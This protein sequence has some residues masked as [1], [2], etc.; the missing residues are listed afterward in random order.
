[1]SLLDVEAVPPQV[2]AW[3]NAN[4]G[5]AAVT[6]YS[7]MTGGFSRVMARLEVSWG[8]GG[9]GVYV[10]RGDPPPE[11]ATLESDRRE[12][13]RLLSTLAGIDEIPTPAARWFIDEAHLGAPAIVIDFLD[14]GSL[15]ASLDRGLDQ[16]EARDRF[17]DLMAA[18][19]RVTPDRVPCL[20]A[21]S[22]WDDHMD[23]LIGRW[24]AV[25]DRHCESAPI[26]RYIASWLDRRRPAPAPLRLVHG[27]F[28]QGNIVDA[29]DGW[30][31]VDWEFARIG[32]PREDLGYYNAYASA[33]PPNLIDADMEG[34]LARFREKTGLD[35]EQVNPV[36]L[37]YFTVLATIGTI[38]PLYSAVAAMAAGE[39]RGVAVAYN[40]QLIPV[41][42]ENFLNAIDQLEAAIAAAEEA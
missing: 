36:T 5:E 34:F 15:Q 4:V 32:D 29:P 37:G 19:S 31:M 10:L 28:Q 20:P 18:V 1:M 13:W 9:D 3:L 38:D 7:I 24:R 12:E 27:D 8:E 30:Q 40:T 17:V 21:P 16:S 23:T 11:M 35:E 22:S 41:G 2:E 26:V 14:G 42:S 25:A 39:R 6:H 33:V